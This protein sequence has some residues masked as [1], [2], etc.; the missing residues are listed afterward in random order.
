LHDEA[1]GSGQNFCVIKMRKP[2]EVEVWRAL[3]ATAGY[4]GNYA[5]ICI[6][7]DEDVDIWDPAMINWAISFNVRP[8]KD[9]QVARG[10][11]PGLDPS[12]YPPGIPTHVSRMSSTHALL[13]NATRPWPYPPISLP[14]KEYMENAKKIWDELGLPDLAPRN[15]WFGY[16]LGAWT[17]QDEREAD[18]AVRGDYWLTGTDAKNRRVKS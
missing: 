6:A 7:V 8:E 1:S 12:A 4:G 13:I 3:N 11:S 16:S 17:E 5:K 18:L 2:S 15:P 14:K 9:V 10:K